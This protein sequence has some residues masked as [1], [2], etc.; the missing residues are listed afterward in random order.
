MKY[1]AYDTYESNF[2]TFE[3]ESEAKK[4]AEDC[5]EDY[6]NGDEW[7]DGIECSIGY[8][9]IKSESTELWR[10]DRDNYT[11]EELSNLGGHDDWELLID[12]GINPVS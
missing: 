7:P 9:E 6:R 1:M 11:D 2:E 8:S 10:K 5:L 4:W 3:N 12:Y